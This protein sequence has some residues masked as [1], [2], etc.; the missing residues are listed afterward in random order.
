MRHRLTPVRRVIAL[1]AVLGL[2]GCGS[3]VVGGQ[4]STSGTSGTSGSMT[5]ADSGPPTSAPF[6][7]QAPVEFT[8]RAEHVASTLRASGALASY[9]HDLVLTSPRIEW[10]DI[11]GSGDLKALLGNG[12]YAAGPAV[13]DTAGRGTIRF[14]D[15]RTREVTLTGARTTLEATK[16]GLPGCV[17]L[18]DVACPFLMTSAR[19]GTM[20]VTT[21]QGPADVPA[22][23][24]LGDGLRSPHVIVA[25]DPA[26]LRGLPKPVYDSA[27]WPGNLVGA[28]SVLSAQGTAVTVRL[29]GFGEGE[30][31]RAA[32]VYEAAD[33][34]VVGGS[35]EREDRDC[36]GIDIGYSAAATL[37]L[38]APLGSRPV[39]EVAWGRFL[40]PPEPGRS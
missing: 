21:N 35:G 29:D 2:A 20:R 18:G 17:G 36:L 23:H 27:S 7:R 38:S 13:T 26:A 37:P 6:V 40:T 15:G 4:S 16:Q 32:H 19:L 31:D 14:L 33:I 11:G 12:G 10:A 34:V 22:W 24:F 39:V 30:R 9:A 25:V 3:A 28:G 5:V 1:A 8:V